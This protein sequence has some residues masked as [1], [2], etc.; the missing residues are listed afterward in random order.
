MWK[1][2]P[3]PSR[4]GEMLAPGQ[5][6]LWWLESSAPEGLQERPQG[7]GVTNPAQCSLPASL[8]PAPESCRASRP[9][10]GTQ[11]CWD[12]GGE[13]RLSS[14]CGRGTSGVRNPSPGRRAQRFPGGPFGKAKLMPPPHFIQA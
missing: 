10:A 2:E 13:L 3:G 12:G 5:L 4:P 7:T 11:H 8:A 14:S 9:A 6:W 1:A